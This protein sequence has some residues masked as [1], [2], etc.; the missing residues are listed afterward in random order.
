[1]DK[2]NDTFSRFPNDHTIINLSNTII[3]ELVKLPGLEKTISDIIKQNMKEIT[4]IVDAGKYENEKPQILFN[5]ERINAFTSNRKQIALMIESNFV[6][7]LN[8]LLNTTLKDQ[9]T[10]NLNENLINN[11]FGLLTKI[12]DE[13]KVNNSQYLEVKYH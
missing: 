13:I 7:T 10:S 8:Q 3:N 5:L 9:D 4:D 2:L 6:K 11:E 12:I 1:M